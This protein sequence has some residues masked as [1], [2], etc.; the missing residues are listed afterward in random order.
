MRETKK[1]SGNPNGET[2]DLVNV[3]SVAAI[4]AAI[5]S[6]EFYDLKITFTNIHVIVIMLP[7]LLHMTK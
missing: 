5:V 4:V 1:R 6:T 3:S 2:A 7:S